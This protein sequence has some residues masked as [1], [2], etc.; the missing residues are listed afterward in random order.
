[1]DGCEGRNVFNSF[2]DVLCQRL[3]ASPS[4]FF[5]LQTPGQVKKNVV[6]KAMK[7]RKNDETMMGERGTTVQLWH[8]ADGRSDMAVP[9]RSEH[10]SGALLTPFN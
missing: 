4:K 3:R 9:L 1:M 5:S 6:V 2:A 7:K 8:V 10:G